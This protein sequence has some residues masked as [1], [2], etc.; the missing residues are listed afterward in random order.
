MAFNYCT[1]FLQNSWEALVMNSC[2][3]RTLQCVYCVLWTLIQQL[4]RC[5]FYCPD[6]AS[7]DQRFRSFNDIIFAEKPPPW[8]EKPTRLR[9]ELLVGKFSAL[10]WFSTYIVIYCVT[11]DTVSFFSE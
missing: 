10:I 9:S 6:Y 8:S 1:Q 11:S 2:R 3:L 7:N 5:F 4:I